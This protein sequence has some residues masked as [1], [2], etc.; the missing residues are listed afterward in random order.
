MNIRNFSREEVYKY[1]NLLSTESGRPE[2]RLK[3]YTMSA[4]PSVQ[5]VWTPFTNKDHKLNTATFPNKDLSQPANIPP[6]ATE[7]LLELYKKQKDEEKL[8]ADKQEVKQI[9]TQ[10]AAVRS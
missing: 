9:E 5:G 3:C 1:L 8:V 6:S 10:K 4:F 2:A 7:L